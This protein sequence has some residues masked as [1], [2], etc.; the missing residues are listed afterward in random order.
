MLGPDPA[1]LRTIVSL[2]GPPSP[3][4]SGC[5]IMSGCSGKPDGPDVTLVMGW[6]GEQIS[7]LL[8]S[9]IHHQGAMEARKERQIELRA[10]LCGT[11]GMGGNHVSSP[12]HSTFLCCFNFP[13]IM[14]FPSDCGIGMIAIAL[15]NITIQ[16][17]YSLCN[18][19]QLLFNH[20]KVF[21]AAQKL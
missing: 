4:S 20:C 1:S 19:I 17:F 5:D 8:C 14:I 6:K 7:F 10:V 13:T 11:G 2:P 16:S 12:W 21:S 15:N 3:S 9:F 18:K